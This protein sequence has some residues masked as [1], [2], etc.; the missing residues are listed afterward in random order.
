MH[1]VPFKLRETS[2]LEEDDVWDHQLTNVMEQSP[3]FDRVPLRGRD[4]HVFPEAHHQY[5]DA[6]CMSLGL[7]IAQFQGTRQALDHG[8]VRGDQT[9]TAAPQVPDNGTTL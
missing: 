1:N 3:L 9:F 8:I 5:A 6:P 4:A 2:R 7:D